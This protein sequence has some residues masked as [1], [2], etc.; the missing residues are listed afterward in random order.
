MLLFDDSNGTSDIKESSALRSM[1]AVGNEFMTFDDGVSTVQ[2]SGEFVRIEKKQDEEVL[3][4]FL[5]LHETS[6]AFTADWSAVFTDGEYFNLAPET[7]L[8]R[9]TLFFTSESSGN[10]YKAFKPANGTPELIRS[11]R[12]TRIIDDSTVYRH[13][14]MLD[15]NFTAIG[16][17]RRIFPLGDGSVYLVRDVE[18]RAGRYYYGAGSDGRRTRSTRVREITV[19]V[20]GVEPFAVKRVAFSFPVR[21][22]LSQDVTGLIGSASNPLVAPDYVDS[23]RVYYSTAG[24][25]WGEGPDGATSRFIPRGGDHAALFALAEPAVAKDDN[26]K[27]YTAMVAVFAGDDDVSYAPSS[28]AYRLT[29]RRTLATGGTADSKIIFPGLPGAAR[30]ITPRSMTLHRHS[31]ARLSLRVL[32]GT[33]AS[34]YPSDSVSPV[35]ASTIVF[36][37]ENNGAMWS[38]GYEIAGGLNFGYGSCLVASR[39]ELLLLS[40]VPEYSPTTATV[41]RATPS[42]Q[43]VIGSIHRSVLNA[44]LFNDTSFGIPYMPRGFGGVVYRNTPTGRVKRLWM[45]YDPVWVQPA[46]LTQ[47]LAYPG[48]RPCIVVSDDGGVS[49][50]R[51]LLPTPWGFRAG[52]VVSAGPTELAILVLSARKESGESV[53]ATVYL[54]KDGGD[55]WKPTGAKATLPG[56][57]RAD[58]NIVIGQVLGSGPPGPR[59]RQ[60]QDINDAWTEYNPGELHPLIVLRDKDGKLLNS[61][62]ARP[63]MVDARI[64]EPADG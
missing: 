47:N 58:G 41:V 39:D 57:T 63:W 61:N 10:D 56:T 11:P 53:P 54:S 36:W 49:W 9:R 33:S 13:P 42:G 59:P 51:R 32:F 16:G 26:G 1:L 34:S 14:W 4:R 5:L 48:A 28:A 40:E 22:G 52:F 43:S 7:K 50:Q 44:G 45:Q 2:R 64:Q 25:W 46:S 31:P 6:D 29:C 38:A 3:M 8:A 35:V 55:S 60:M 17:A 27:Q 24:T 20:M 30:Y 62:P 37:T 12:F 23:G 18:E 19:S 21:S 15:S